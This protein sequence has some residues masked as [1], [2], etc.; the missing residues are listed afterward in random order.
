M[1]FNQTN[2]V[3]RLDL[4]M[5]TCLQTVVLNLISQFLF[6]RSVSSVYRPIPYKETA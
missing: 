3:Y 2:Q 5:A 6:V 4:A 1:T